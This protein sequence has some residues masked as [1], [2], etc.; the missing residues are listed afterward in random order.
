VMCPLIRITLEREQ[1]IIEEL[2]KTSRDASLALQS[3]PSGDST[4]NRKTGFTV[5]R[6]KTLSKR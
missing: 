2:V 1:E 6:N 5:D 3:S 4:K